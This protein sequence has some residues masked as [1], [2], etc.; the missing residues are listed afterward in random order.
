MP[1]GGSGDSVAT[2]TSTRPPSRLRKDSLPVQPVNSSKSKDRQ[3]SEDGYSST[4]GPSEDD[5]I[6]EE[7]AEVTKTVN[8]KRKQ[9]EDYAD[10][11]RHRSMSTPQ[12]N[13]VPEFGGHMDSE[14]FK[15]ERIQR[16]SRRNRMEDLGFEGA[17]E[18][19]QKTQSRAESS[20]VLD[21][22]LQ[23]VDLANAMRFIQ[24][25]T[26]IPSGAVDDTGIQPVSPTVRISPTTRKSRNGKVAEIFVPQ[27]PPPIL[28]NPDQPGHDV[29]VQ[30]AEHRSAGGHV[31]FTHPEVEIPSSDDTLSMR[32]GI[33]PP[34]TQGRTSRLPTSSSIPSGLFGSKRHVSNPTSGGKNVESGNTRTQLFVGDTPEQ[35]PKQKRSISERFN[36]NRHLMS[37]SKKPKVVERSPQPEADDE[38]A[39][40]AR[41][42]ARFQE[43]IQS[44]LLE[45]S[46]HPRAE[47]LAYQARSYLQGYYSNVYASVRDRELDPDPI[48]QFDPLAVIRWRKAVRREEA[49][50][51][52]YETSRSSTKGFS[53]G[54]GTTFFEP[55]VR[56]PS[57]SLNSPDMPSTGNNQPLSKPLHSAELLN[58]VDQSD[59]AKHLK[60]SPALREWVVTPSEIVAY[61]N[62]KGVV[63]HFVPSNEFEHPIWGEMPQIDRSPST[64]TAS[65]TRSRSVTSPSSRM[66]Q[67]KAASNLNHHGPPS[68]HG[69]EGA[70]EVDRATSHGRNNSLDAS[71]R[72]AAVIK[73]PLRSIRRH[74]HPHLHP[75]LDRDNSAHSAV[76]SDTENE[77]IRGSRRHPLL[78]TTQ[79]MKLGQS[80]K[81]QVHHVETAPTTS[82][83][84]IPIPENSANDV[85][86]QKIEVHVDPPT[87]L[88]PQS[89][90]ALSTEVSVVQK[91]EFDMVP[92]ELDEEDYGKK[93]RALYSVENAMNRSPAVERESQALLGDFIS[94]VE[95]FRKRRGCLVVDDDLRKV[96]RLQLGYIGQ[97]RT[98]A[99]N[100]E[101][102][103]KPAELEQDSHGK[104]RVDSTQQI[105]AFDPLYSVKHI[106]EDLHD[107]YNLAIRQA[108]EVCQQQDAV[109][110]KVSELLPEAET[111]LAKIGDQV[112]KVSRTIPTASH[113]KKT[114]FL[115]DNQP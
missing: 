54:S 5:S 51:K 40:E 102:S 4:H 73:S 50:R 52:S 106:I 25:Q 70:G 45:L 82:H 27:A 84:S 24:K 66:W 108:I 68:A 97:M 55:R 63:D 9:S 41:D 26:V 59:T 96:R 83:E 39:M 28:H 93:L 1:S 32:S 11:L 61:L 113:L 94:T 64:M 77:G 37:H 49:K 69:S 31:A 86:L 15:A 100:G 74:I 3:V 80:S 38:F 114:E 16:P 17:M 104:D 91:D 18:S 13:A 99:V 7:K 12:M 71:D 115:C 22:L 48:Y 103:G 67:I 57:K 8:R 88:I 62:C 89:E 78:N 53:P 90:P 21:N 79:K 23:S 110:H 47:K 36:L 65:S 107:R 92:V 87:D 19:S 76:A 105:S 10:R 20:A 72:F 95:A 35:E 6:N 109:Q 2:P 33:N 75:H 81:E 46:H 101:A 60:V 98:P 44:A 112:R 14:L 58:R 43:R 111:L 56:T 30:K 34:L 85:S 29:S 42:M